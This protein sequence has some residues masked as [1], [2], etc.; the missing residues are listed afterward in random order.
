MN[1]LFLTHQGDLSGATN[2]ISYLTK[3]LATK[4]HNVYMGCRRE[5]LLWKLLEGSKVNLIPMTF[6]GKM[7]RNNIRHIRDV[8]EQYQIEIINAQSTHDRYTSI[9]SKWIYNLPVK[10]VHTRRQVPKSIGGWLQNSFYVKGTEKIVAV[11][12]ELKNIFV[13]MGI[14]ETHMV[15]VNNGTPREKYENLSDELVYQLKK[16][17]NL[18]EGDVVIGCVSRLKEQHQLIKAL[19]YL[20]PEIKVI[21]V[22]ID[23]GVLDEEIKRNGVKNPIIYAG[24]LDTFTSLH[25]NKLFTI[26]VLP[27]LDEGLSQSILES[28]ALEVPV[29]GT[30]AAGL[31]SQIVEGE[32]GL[33]YENGNIQ[34][35]AD[36]MKQ[37]LY[38]EPLREKLKVNGKFRALETYSIERTIDNYEKLFLQI[39]GK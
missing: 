2:S 10:I 5:S 25:Y 29:V 16:K 28:M 20:S 7:D 39:L 27:S 36:K 19:N 32:S 15:A 11:S 21:F 4:G 31:I 38:N 33:L 17:H 14:P 9:F 30:R 8:V 24:K 12:E 3:G 13:K 37:A 6:K 34:D 1:L 26:A 18:Q 22:G 35:F 23:V